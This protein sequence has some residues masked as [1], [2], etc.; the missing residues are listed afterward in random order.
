MGTTAYFNWYEETIE[1][2]ADAIMEKLS[3]ANQSSSSKA[4][5]SQ[6]Y[7]SLR[8]ETS[9]SDIFQ[10]IKEEM[11]QE[12]KNERDI[13]DANY[14]QLIQ[15]E[16]ACAYKNVGTCI[17]RQAMVSTYSFDS[18][19]ILGVDRGVEF[20]TIQGDTD[21]MRA[22]GLIEYCQYD[23]IYEELVHQV[24]ADNPHLES[25]LIKH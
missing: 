14:R 21:V 16:E 8:L 20:E 24:L 7:L 5:V 25:K 12:N 6:T 2:I 15:S 4:T 11:K 3:K 23:D 9:N 19:Y 18:L 1:S 10:N 13:A 22:Q 17:L